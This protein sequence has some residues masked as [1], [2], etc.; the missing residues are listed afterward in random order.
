MG[1]RARGLSDRMIRLTGHEA[2]IL[3]F[4]AQRPGA[5]NQFQ[6]SLGV[7]ALL[8][9]QYL[10]GAEDVLEDV[11]VTGDAIRAWARERAER[12]VVEKRK[13]CPSCQLLLDGAKKL[14]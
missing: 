8:I 1:V 12:E 10:A 14:P 3:A 13:K 5:L 7:P 4:L 9:A 11:R 6:V 2:S